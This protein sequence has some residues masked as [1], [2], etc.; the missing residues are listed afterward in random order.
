[1]GQLSYRRYWDGQGLARRRGTR[2]EVLLRLG[3]GRHEGEEPYGPK[4][5]RDRM[6][7]GRRALSELVQ[8]FDPLRPPQLSPPRAHESRRSR[9]DVQQRGLLAAPPRRS[10]SSPPTRAHSG[11]PGVGGRIGQRERDRG[12][13]QGERGESGPE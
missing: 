7:I 10:T 5:F 9:P 2:T 4:R 11:G 3:V 13:D 12:M 6:H 8:L 1:M